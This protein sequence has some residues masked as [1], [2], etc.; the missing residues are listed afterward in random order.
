[1]K[2]NSSAVDFSN[3]LHPNN[4]GPSSSASSTNNSGASTPLS[5][6][7]SNPPISTL[8]KPNGPLAKA[9]KAAQTTEAKPAS[10]TTELPRPYKCTM[11][12]KAFHR[13]EHQS[14]HIRTHTGEKP[15][16]CQ[17]PGCTKR[18]SRSDELTRHSRIHKNPKPREAGAARNQ[19]K[20]QQQQA[21]SQMGS[22]GMMPPP[23]SRTINSAP[24]SAIVS[25]NVSPPHNASMLAQ[26]SSQLNPYNRG[27]ITTSTSHIDISMLAQAAQ[28][29]EPIPTSRS[30]SN[31]QSMLNSNS[32]TR[33]TFFAHNNSLSSRSNFGHSHF[34][35]GSGFSNL[36]LA[37]YHM[38]RSSAHDEHS[39]DHSSHYGYRPLK[40][41]RPNSPYS[42]APS[43]P[44]FSHSSLSP[45]PDQTP[46][47]TPAQSPRMSA[48]QM[49]D[50]Q[51]SN[52]L[53]V[54]HKQSLN[55]RTPALPPMEPPQPT[56][57]NSSHGHN[58]V[59]LPPR[60][61]GVSLVEII[62]RT[63]ASQRK[64]PVPSTTHTGLVPVRELF[65]ESLTGSYGQSSRPANQWPSDA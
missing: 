9:A 22:D 3:L 35:S 31:L 32:A 47:A 12:D 13:L 54:I 44:T 48:Y 64:L 60:R 28:H 39:E 14:R 56:L 29:V 4:S 42:T 25:P 53:P 8:L 37:P 1:M 62:N 11:C 49:A 41:S 40:R 6:M 30:A 27:A 38:S 58:S 51:A 57:Q 24:G 33:N 59:Q 20:Q 46:I 43:S 26:Y 34:G 15:H 45:T 5:E 55:Q 19:Q 50:S 61:T 10:A 21:Q 36:G 65:A 2:R 7:S 16:V 17:H 52:Q 63:D 23:A 18:F